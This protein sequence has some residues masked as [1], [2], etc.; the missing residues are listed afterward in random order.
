MI[1][2]RRSP[3]IFFGWWTVLVGTWL[4]FWGSAYS[5]YAFSA[6]FKPIS[7]ELGFSRAATS[8]ASSLSRLEGGLLGPLTGWLSDK[9]GPKWVV[10]FGISFF[11]LGLIMM[12]YIGPLWS[13]YLVW[14][15]MI[16]IGQT[17]SSGVPMDKAITSWFVKKR[18]LALSLRWIASGVLALPIIAWLITTQGWRIT[19]VIG[20]IVAAVIGLPL[21]WFFLKPHRP[22]YYG[23]L[24]D[25]AA[26][27]EEEDKPSQIIDKGIE[28]AQEIDEVEF[29]LRQALRTPTF[30]MILIAQAGYMG[31]HQ[32]ISVHLIPFL[33]DIGIDLTRAATIM[34]FSGIIGIAARLIGGV[35]ADRINNKQLRFLFGGAIL[36]QG[37]GIAI[38]L[39]D[40]T[41]ASVYPFL[42]LN[43]VGF[44]VSIVLASL[45]WG[46][47]FGRKAFG[48]IRGSSTMGAMPM[49]ILGPIYAG[50]IFD[51]SGN[52][53]VAFRVI[54]V[55]FALASV[56][57]FFARPPK[58]PAE[59]SDIS[60]I[61]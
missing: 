38:F 48:S 55:L 36:L 39:L 43:Y 45:I 7:S 1:K 32:T 12:N 4:N 31:S 46:R 41:I 17:T 16:G 18:G 20:G 26:A 10:I 60:K 15:V 22:E 47:Y 56:L 6:L 61:V 2:K 54:A 40:K 30:W 53:I 58:P 50:W 51:T 49:V 21:A 5:V 44:G 25:G 27:D 9:F 23:L 8:V 34:T 33:T 24:P 42:I 28:Y 14:G 52:Y 3:K 57:M 35:F 11:S 19:S 13:F 37:I 59:V 29:T